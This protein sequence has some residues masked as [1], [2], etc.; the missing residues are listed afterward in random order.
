MRVSMRC[1]NAAR[2]IC[3]VWDWS[4]GEG[5]G[6]KEEGFGGAQRQV[7]LRQ[8]E[9]I[10]EL[11]RYAGAGALPQEPGSVGVARGPCCRDRRAAR[12]DSVGR[13]DGQSRARRQHGATRCG[14]GAGS[15]TIDGTG[16]SRGT[17]P[18][19]VLRFREQPVLAPRTQPLAHRPASTR[20]N[21]GADSDSATVVVQPA[22]Q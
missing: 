12:A 13:S 5:Y 10:K 18:G 7:S 2:K 19:V 15:G 3:I 8:R 9:E 22:D 20:G 21:P 6:A 1:G 14:A 4:N 16:G 17:A 11:L